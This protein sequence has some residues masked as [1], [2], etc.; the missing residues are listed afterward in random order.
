EPRGRAFALGRGAD[1][2]RR[3]RGPCGRPRPR[4]TA[5]RSRPRL[6]L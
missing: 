3:G 2:R 1:D 6:R 5:R 4:R